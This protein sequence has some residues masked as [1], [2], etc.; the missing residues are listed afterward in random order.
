M[1][2]EKQKSRVPEE[3]E[4]EDIYARLVAPCPEATPA[5][6][7]GEARQEQRRSRPEHGDGSCQMN[8]C[9]KCH[10]RLPDGNPAM[11][12]FNVSPLQL[13]YRDTLGEKGGLFSRVFLLA[14]LAFPVSLFLSRSFN[15]VAE[16][17]LGGCFPRQ[18]PL[19]ARVSIPSPGPAAGVGVGLHLASPRR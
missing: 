3:W 2:L 19:W 15:S 8:R 10:E 14:L 13:G 18:A 17:K 9:G 11:D 1:G 5:I 6:A 12:G 4:G 7:R 16:H